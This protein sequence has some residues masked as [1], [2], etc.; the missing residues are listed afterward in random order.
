MRNPRKR[1][2]SYAPVDLAFDPNRDDL[3]VAHDPVAIAHAMY[4]PS[5]YQR[6]A[7][8]QP[9]TSGTFKGWQIKTR[10]FGIETQG[11]ITRGMCVVDR[12]QL[13]NA[14]K[15]LNKVHEEAQQSSEDTALPSVASSKSSTVIPVIKPEEANDGDW[16]VVVASP[17]SDW[18][19]TIFCSA[20]GI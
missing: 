8:Q 18:F 7:H 20:L 17:G 12:R 9:F 16:D 2:N 19:T 10:R 15:G 5:P 6:R 1:T 11:I 14:K 3:F 13:G 4:C